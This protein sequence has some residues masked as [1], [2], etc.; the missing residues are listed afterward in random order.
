[1]HGVYI[2]SELYE[3]CVFKIIVF[4]GTEIAMASTRI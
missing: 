3:I 1:M 4:Y 2:A